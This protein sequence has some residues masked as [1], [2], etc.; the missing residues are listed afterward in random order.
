[1]PPGSRDG[2]LRSR[3]SSAGD[4]ELR[5]MRQ[6]RAATR[7][8]APEPRAASCRSQTWP[9][10]AAAAARAETRAAQLARRGPAATRSECASVGIG[11]YIGEQTNRR[12]ACGAAGG[13]IPQPYRPLLRQSPAPE[14]DGAAPARAGSDTPADGDPSGLLADGKTVPNDKIVDTAAGG[15][16]RLGAVCTDRPTRNPCGTIWR[17]SAG[18]IESARR[19]TPAARA[20]MA[21]S[22][23]SLTTT[24]AAGGGDRHDC[25][26]HEP[27]QAPVVE[28]GFADLNDVDARRA[29]RDRRAGA[30]CRSWQ[31][32]TRR[33]SVTRQ[34]SGRDSPA[35]IDGTASVGRDGTSGVSRRDANAAPSSATPASSVT[36]PSP[37]TAPRAYGLAARS[38][39]QR[40]A[41][42]PKELRSQNADQ[43]ATI[44]INPASRK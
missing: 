22:T 1:M 14:V 7:H 34:M 38:C 12:H 43:G 16:D 11:R 17:T 20:A 24:R 9:A 30:G 40:A 6:C 33:R 44:R 18:V 3:A 42:R 21:M 32:T 4:R 25:R 35:V 10:S 13:N 28:T 29:R 5:M 26:A 36:S 23:R 31:A 15:S 39:E 19:C 37:D 8:D 27:G 2:S 41:P